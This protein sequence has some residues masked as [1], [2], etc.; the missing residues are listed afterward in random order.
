[1]NDP[2]QFNDAALGLRDL[3][4]AVRDERRPQRDREQRQL[5]GQEMEG[6]NQ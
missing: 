4:R 2:L 6:C 3:T 1:M 5:K